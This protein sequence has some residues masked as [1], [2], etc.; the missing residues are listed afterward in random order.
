MF[1]STIVIYNLPVKGTQNGINWQ[2]YK[3]RSLL[4]TFTEKNYISN[5]YELLWC[6]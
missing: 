6:R 1:T 3:T 5:K 2:Q 4:H